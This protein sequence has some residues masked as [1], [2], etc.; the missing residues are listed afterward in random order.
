V[1]VGRRPGVRRDAETFALEA[2][3]D[4]GIDGVFV[5]NFEV[6]GTAD[7]EDHGANHA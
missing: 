3:A 1:A 6:E 2:G 7:V 5:A 4:V